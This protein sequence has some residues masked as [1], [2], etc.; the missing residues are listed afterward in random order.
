MTK[1]RAKINHD[2]SSLTL[3][4]KRT[5]LQIES[6]QIGESKIANLS[7][8]S[9]LISKVSKDLKGLM[10]KFYTN[11]K[12]NNRSD[13]NEKLRNELITTRSTLETL[14][15]QLDDKDHIRNEFERLDESMKSLIDNKAAFK[16]VNV[17]ENISYVKR[18]EEKSNSLIDKLQEAN[19]P[20][21][22]NT[23]P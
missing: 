11:W 6:I 5:Q 18:I 17:L 13:E 9:Q 23:N 14:Y 22:S 19:P 20:S 15:K 4:E 1:L 16:K 2:S 8:Q 10:I 3:L 7:V 21:G 12:K